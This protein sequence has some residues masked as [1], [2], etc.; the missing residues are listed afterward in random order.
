MGDRVMSQLTLNGDVSG[1]V[2]VQ[3]PS[4]PTSWT[5]TLPSAAP[6]ANGQYLSATTGGVASW[7]TLGPATY[8]TLVGYTTTV[9][10][11]SP[12]TLTASSTYNQFFTGSTAQTVVLPVVSTLAQGWTYQI[13]NTSTANLTVNSSGSNLVATVIPGTTVVFVCILTSGTTAASWNYEVNG[14]AAQTGTGNVVLAT[15]PSITTATLTNPTITNYVETYYN[16]GTVTSTV[17][18]DITNGTFQSLTMTSATALTVTLPTATAGKSFILIVRQPASGTAN[19]VSWA[20]SPPVKWSGGTAPTITATVAKADI[21]T[22][23]CDGT[24][25]Y[26]SIVQNYT[27]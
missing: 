14:F 17:T 5:L 27:P 12:V 9:T 24:N 1:Y 23:V 7:S 18:I 10:S 22:F 20:A 6:T 19:A 8:A 15:S 4:A 3:S 11:A 26:G 2:T 21:L 25:W 13:T 16:I